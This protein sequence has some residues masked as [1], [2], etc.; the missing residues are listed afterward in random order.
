MPGVPRRRR[1]GRRP[2]VRKNPVTQLESVT[3]KASVNTTRTEYRIG[4]KVREQREAERKRLIEIGRKRYNE[5]FGLRKSKRK[6]VPTA[7]FVEFKM[8]LEEKKKKKK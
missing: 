5:D 3:G 7:K 2:K 4:K 1:I 6:K 8:S